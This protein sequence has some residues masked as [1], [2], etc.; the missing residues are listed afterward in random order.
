MKRSITWASGILVVSLACA[1]AMGAAAPKAAAP[2]AEATK[3]GAAQAESG[4][5]YGRIVAAYMDGDWDVLDKELRAPPK[6]LT[7]LTRAQ[8]ADVTYVRQAAAECHP[9]WWNPCKAGQKA[10]FQAN[11][12]NQ[13]IAV[14]Y[15]PAKTDASVNNA[16]GKRSMTAG[17]PAAD[18]DSTVHAEH[19][20]SKG[21]LMN[22]GVWL[23]MG[24]AA[25]LPTTLPANLDEATKLRISLYIELRSDLTVFYYAS[26]PARRWALYLFSLCYTPHHA[27]AQMAASRRA[28]TAMFLAEVLKS[29]SK[30]PT[31]K[32]P[33]TLEADGAEEKLCDYFRKN[34]LRR[35]DRW[36]IAEDK[37][38]R[39][40]VKAF[41]AASD[42]PT[43]MTGRG[44]LPSGLAFSLSAE[45]DV[46]LRAKRETWIKAQFD[47]AAAKG[48]AKE[49]AKEAAKAAQ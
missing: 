10:T 19:G 13:A 49:A 28:A 43:S 17:W 18:M 25:A 38:F 5:L 21:D 26:P 1:A 31:L 24:M 32:L 11:V 12:W 33:D 40:A 14:T 2:A 4:D 23:G 6:D 37:S 20:Y 47:K 29:P 22:V 48:A 39:E 41:A 3:A 44:I 42:Q 7:R 36:T 15:D 35:E 34:R 9:P 8:Q 27:K 45:E 16:G 30:Y 46:P